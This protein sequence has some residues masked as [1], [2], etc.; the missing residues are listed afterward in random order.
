MI[1]GGG[2]WSADQ[3]RAMKAE[4]WDEGFLSGAKQEWTTDESD[5]ET[6]PYKE[7]NDSHSE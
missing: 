1:R 7:T 3:I 2:W 6:N 5:N 4:A